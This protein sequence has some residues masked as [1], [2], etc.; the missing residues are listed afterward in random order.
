MRGSGVYCGASNIFTDSG[1]RN[2][3]PSTEPSPNTAS[4]KRPMSAA[5]VVMLP[6]GLAWVYEYGTGS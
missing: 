2:R 1:R 4:M 5:V 6:A 3:S